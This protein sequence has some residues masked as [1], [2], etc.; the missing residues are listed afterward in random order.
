[1]YSLDW[2]SL[3]LAVIA[4][5]QA[6]FV[7]IKEFQACTFVKAREGSVYADVNVDFTAN[8][9]EGFVNYIAPVML[10]ALMAQNNSIQ[11][12]GHTYQAAVTAIYAEKVPDINDTSFAI[13]NNVTVWES[14]VFCEVES[15]QLCKNGGTCSVDHAFGSTSCSCPSGFTGAYCETAIV[16]SSTEVGLL[17]SVGTLLPVAAILVIAVAITFLCRKKNRSQA[18]DDDKLF[19]RPTAM[20]G[21]RSGIVSRSTVPLYGQS[22][23]S[24]LGGRSALLNNNNE[25]SISGSSDSGSTVTLH[26]DRLHRDNAVSWADQWRTIRTSTAPYDRDIAQREH[27]AFSQRVLNPERNP[28]NTPS[29]SDDFQ[30]LRGQTR[31][32][33]PPMTFP[34]AAFSSNNY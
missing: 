7:H 11:L 23:G 18:G 24:F 17:A 6:I 34:S 22:I 16:T 32:S 33:F 26:R 2:W 10:Q 3:K 21:T 30:L 1:M 20:E 19:T 31:P 27:A 15:Y 8:V 25:G 13:N 28:V 14:S 4:A 29:R 5:I 12:N 9:T